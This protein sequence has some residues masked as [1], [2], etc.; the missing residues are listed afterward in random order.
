MSAWVGEGG[1]ARLV[2]C[3]RPEAR[4]GEVVIR[5]LAA[6]VNR[7]DLLQVAGH[8]PPPAGASEVLGL[9]VA[10][11][12]VQGAG[13]FKPGDAVMALL[14]GGGYAEYV[15]VDAGSVLP[16]PQGISVEQGAAIPEAF[17]TAYQCLCHLGQLAAGQ[18][19]LLHAGASGVGTAAIQLARH[20]G[21]EVW[22]TV[23][24]EAKLEACRALGA[25]GGVNHRQGDFAQALPPVDLIVDPVGG[26][27]LG[28]NLK[29]LKP[30]GQL[31]QLAM[32]GGRRAEVDLALVL[33]KRLTVRGSTLRSQPKA[34]KAALV[35]GLWQRF[36]AAFEGGE[37]APV[38]DS[39]Y[40]FESVAE[41]HRRMADNANTGK[42]VLKLAQ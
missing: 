21:A 12:V 42:L 3:P 38:V 10:G 23:G 14:A 5:V 15:A 34:V 31:I 35:Q 28:R 7:A 17:V 18:R 1:Q 8:Y 6:G 40:A 22:V 11:E 16:L 27:Y 37:I 36:G 26:D 39:A 32:M 20:L 41:A 25:T 9:E 30:D 24:S 2:R 4:P 33:A 13:S 19:V 29:L